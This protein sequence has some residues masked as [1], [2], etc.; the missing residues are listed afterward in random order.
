MSGQTDTSRLESVTY[1][2]TEAAF[3]ARTGSPT[4]KRLHCWNDQLSADLRYTAEPNNDERVR[5]HDNPPEIRGTTD[6]SKGFPLKCYFKGIPTAQKLSASA[7]PAL[8]SQHIVLAH[9]IGRGYYAVGCAISS[10]ASA[11]VFTVDATD[12]LRVGL[13]VE[14]EISTGV[15][16][17]AVIQKLSAF[18]GAGDVT[19]ETPLSTTPAGTHVRVVRSYCLTERGTSTVGVERKYVQDTGYEFRLLGG[20]GAMSFEFGDYEKAYSW[21]WT[22]ELDSYQ[23]DAAL[24]SPSFGSYAAADD[25]MDPPMVWSPVVHLGASWVRGTTTRIEKFGMEIPGEWEKTF[26]GSTTTGVGGVVRTSGRPFAARIK[27]TLRADT[28]EA[29]VY[30]AKTIRSFMLESTSDTSTFTVYAPRLEYVAAMG[31]KPVAIGKRIA[32][33]C[34]FNC[35]APTGRTGQTSPSAEEADLQFSPIVL[36]L[37]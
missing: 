20:R 37:S 4:L 30:A 2:F 23:R 29:A 17:R 7:T 26:D 22:P 15:Y 32:Y 25:D 34:T 19:L 6:G 10:A 18:T 24:T 33:E 28:A 12:T 35:L 11:S 9:A 3:G 13:L 8:L 21:T 31:V 27:L 14:V 5:Q 36:G 1:V 16:E